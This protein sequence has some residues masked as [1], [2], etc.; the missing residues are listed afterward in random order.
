MNKITKSADRKVTFIFDVVLESGISFAQTLL[1]LAK[2]KGT[3]KQVIINTLDFEQYFCIAITKS[4]TDITDMFIYDSALNNEFR[5]NG[6]IH[7]PSDLLSLKI[8]RS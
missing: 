8:S 2:N 1:V 6:P 7:C 3:H 4:F 5:I